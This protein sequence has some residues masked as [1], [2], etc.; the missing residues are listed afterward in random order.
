MPKAPVIES[1]LTSMVNDVDPHLAT[2][3]STRPKDQIT[4]AFLETNGFELTL[5]NEAT[6]YSET[7]PQV[8]SHQNPSTE[9]FSRKEDA[10]RKKL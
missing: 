1:K 7:L 4:E 3:Y 8:D 9:T 2:C 6:V 5:A 10:R